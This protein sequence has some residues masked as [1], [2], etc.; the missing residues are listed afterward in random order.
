ME[1]NEDAIKD[2]LAQS[3]DRRYEIYP[4]GVFEETSEWDDLDAH[5]R[6]WS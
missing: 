6:V 1:L 3:S 5:D 4:K 2:H